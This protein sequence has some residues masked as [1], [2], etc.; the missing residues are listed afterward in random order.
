M[1]SIVFTDLDGTLLDNEWKLSRKNYDTLV[2]LGNRRVVRVVVTGRSLYSAR[3]VLGDD[4]PIDY[5][6][7]STGAGIMNW[8]KKELLLARNIP[9]KTVREYAEILI[10]NKINF[11]L[12]R[13]IPESHF[14]Y[15]YEGNGTP[16]DFQQRLELYNPFAQPFNYSAHVH[17][18]STQFLSILPSSKFTV[19]NEFVRSKDLMLS[20][21]KTTSPLLNSSLWLEI[22]APEVSKGHAT[23][24]L[25]A[26]LNCKQ[27]DCMVIGNDFNDV[28][29]LDLSASSFVV[30][31]APEELKKRYQT[32]AA[33]ESDG[34]SEAVNLWLEKI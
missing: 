31:N 11:M 6:I 24:Y 20:I 19:I 22:Y 14:F 12:H 34:F 1:G 29:M 9:K 16:P 7:F 18:P 30:E 26:I 17:L 27:Q 10:E 13:E 21:I 25:A 23:D 32:L 28:D 15:Y 3:K 5:L 2:Y 33:N 8:E 4:F